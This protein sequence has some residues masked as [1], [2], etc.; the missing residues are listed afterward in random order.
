MSPAFLLGRESL[1]FFPAMS[2]VCSPGILLVQITHSWHLVPTWSSVAP[3]SQLCFGASLGGMCPC[4][5][6]GAPGQLR[7]CVNCCLVCG[8][9]A[10]Q[11]ACH[12]SVA[13]ESKHV[14]W[15]E[16]HEESSLCPR[17][18]PTQ[19]CWGMPL[20]KKEKKKEG[21]KEKR[22]LANWIKQELKTNRSD[23]SQGVFRESQ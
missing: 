8:Q 10:Q 17:L 9:G 21:K 16:S 20:I 6:V 5:S 23:N 2:W 11:L 12:F 18:C 13:F 14:T 19:L 15:E 22:E 1:F 7:R 4:G 3:S